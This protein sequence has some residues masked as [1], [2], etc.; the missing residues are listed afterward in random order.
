MKQK[1]KF[2]CLMIAT[3]LLTGCVKMDISMEVKDDKSMDLSIITAYDSSLKES[4]QEYQTSSDEETVAEYEKKG[5]YVQ[6]Y[7]EDGKSGYKMTKQIKNIDECSTEGALEKSEMTEA[8]TGEKQYMFTVKKSFFMDTYTASYDFS[9]MSGMGSMSDSGLIEEYD[10]NCIYGY[11][12]SVTDVHCSYGY[13]D[14]PTVDEATNKKNY[15]A[16]VAEMKK[17]EEQ[18]KNSLDMKFNL[19]LPYGASSSNATSKKGNTLVWDLSQVSEVNFSFNMY[20]IKNIA[21]V[22]G[23]GLVVLII[24]IATIVFNIKNKH[25]NPSMHVGK[26]YQPN[27]MNGDPYTQIEPSNSSINNIPQDSNINVQP[28]PVVQPTV[29]PVQPQQTSTFVATGVQQQPTNTFVNTGVQ[30]QPMNGFGNVDNQSQVVQPQGSQPSIVIPPMMQQQNT[31]S[32][33]NN[34]Q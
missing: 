9:S 18:L 27:F 30:Q 19:K 13:D 34:Q 31:N 23:I 14:G 20:N 25:N 17:E 15:E 16:Y 3:F 7:E 12:G 32:D 6:K 33:Q 28:Q 10:E 8:L 11:G 26:A 21:I 1:F 4:L 29:P 24:T 2:L 5:F 22:G